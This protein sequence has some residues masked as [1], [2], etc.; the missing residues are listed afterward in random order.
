MD[1]TLQKIQIGEI[2]IKLG[3][4]TQTQLETAIERQKITGYRLGETLINLGFIEKN[5]LLEIVA[6]Q[7]NIPLVDVR[8]YSFDPALVALL[9]EIDARRYRAMVLQV[10]NEN[11]SVAMVDPQDLIAQDQLEKIFKKP[12]KISLT[13]EDDLLKSIDN[14]YRHTTE[15][16]IL[17][18]ALSAELTKNDYDSQKLTEGYSQLDVPIL[19]LLQSIFED[20]VQVGASDVHI[21]P[22]EYLLRIRQRIDGVLHE[23]V[24][25]EKQVAEALALRLKLMAS[26][27]I[28][29]KRL[30]QDGRFSIRVHEKNYDIRLSTLPTQYGESVVMRLLNQSAELVSLEQMGADAMMVSRLK[31][32]LTLPNG[33]LLVTGPTGSGKTTT[34]YSLLNDMNTSERKI[35]TVEDPIEYRMHRINQVQVL[36]KINLTFAN[37]L[38]SILRQDPDVIMIG[39]LRDQETVSIALRAAMTG[40]FVLATLHTNDAISS[41]VRLLD[42]GAEGYIVASVLRVAIAQRLVRRICL[43]CITPYSLSSSEKI[44]LSA[45][46]P[47]LKNEEIHYK[48][49]KGCM[50]CH[51]TGFKNQIGI[52]ELLEINQEMAD[53]LR[54]SDTMAF[55]HLARENTFFRPL[56]KNGFDLVRSGVTTLSELIRIIGENL[57]DVPVANSMVME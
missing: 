31:K 35:I 30:P 38:R 42:M 34:L 46:L 45:M 51:H 33:L 43:N 39:E 10:N 41:I 14:F 15:I 18:E 17:A 25:K 50:Y 19:K 40:H 52:F 13:A 1:K 37:V 9:P 32:I 24:I 54:V 12:I 56:I 4:I 27:N 5:Q 8:N 3:L 20:A 21:E 6:K 26:L 2:L 44:W 53:A 47:D 23:H 36:T 16:N 55:S 28:T 11:I 22:D 49:G 57:E 7:L 48:F 29:E